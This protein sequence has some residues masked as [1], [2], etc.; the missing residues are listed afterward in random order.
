[1]GTTSRKL[2]E[3]T[4]LKP[5]HPRYTNRSTWTYARLRECTTAGDMS[6]SSNA[7][8]RTA[9]SP[10]CGPKH[11][12]RP[13]RPRLDI[14]PYVLPAPH[15][16]AHRG[17]SRRLR[18]LQG[19]YVHSEVF[20]IGAKGYFQRPTAGLRLRAVCIEC[21]FDRATSFGHP[22][23]ASVRARPLVL[24]AAVGRSTRLDKQS[25]YLLQHVAPGLS[26]GS[27]IAASPSPRAV[28]RTLPCRRTAFS[29]RLSVPT[30]TAPP[31]TR[32]RLSSGAAKGRA[33]APSKRSFRVRT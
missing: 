17:P 30:L 27:Q 18:Q 31:Y 23:P 16:G 20:W 25:G 7:G 8:T 14:A 21:V 32:Q 1:M 10:Y 3:E 19:S 26:D 13:A 28:Y 33:S 2:T 9:S 4:A 5:M 24:P 6:T 11:K 29:G 15:D 12:G 22:G